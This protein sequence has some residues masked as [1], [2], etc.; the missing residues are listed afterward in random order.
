VSRGLRQAI[1]WT[2]LVVGISAGI[3]IAVMCF[4]GVALAFEKEIIAWADRNVRAVAP[5]QNA[6]AMTVNEAFAK[7]SSA[8]PNV[9]PNTLT[10][11]TDPT[12]G[13]LVAAGRTNAFYLNQYTGTVSEPA[14][15]RTRAFMT[16]MIEWHRF[17]TLQGDNRP[18][19]KMITGACNFAFLFLAAS[20]V[21]LWWPRKWSQTA[22]RGILLF[23]RQ[24]TGKARDWNWHNVIGFWSAP[25]LIVPT[26]T[27]LPI[28]YK[29]AGDAIYKLT[30][31]EPPAQGAGPSARASAKESN[32]NDRAS[33]EPSLSISAILQT[34]RTEVPSASQITIRAGARGPLVVSVKEQNARPRFSTIQLTLDPK[35]S[36]VTKRETYADFNAGRKVRSWT[37]F[38]HTG[39]ALG[40]VGQFVAGLASLGGLI[41]VWT[42]FALA[43]RR[44]FGRKTTTAQHAQ[45][46]PRLAEVAK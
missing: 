35:T 3:V 32:P 13:L 25:V 6:P 33:L 31:T 5:T 12:I 42:G 16:S 4:T 44:F 20:G 28:S 34:V 23:N 8:Q 30:R 9:K 29:W 39:E 46:E 19:G 37:R 11:S 36:A 17:L 10:I 40:P 27:A 15:P 18:R 45:F 21:Y 2:H 41:L 22:L 24:L 7:V 14:S 43:I 38:L 1:F 26:A